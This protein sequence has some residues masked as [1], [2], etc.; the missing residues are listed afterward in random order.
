M[1]SFQKFFFILLIAFLASCKTNKISVVR[2]NFDNEIAVQQNLSFK[3]NSDI[4]PDELLNTWD[5]TQYLQF[6]PQIKGRY[7]WV[8]A[9]ELIFSPEQ[10]F[11]PG[12][13]Y[14]A[15][16]L[17]I[18]GKIGNQNKSV[19]SSSFE[20]HTPFLQIQS[21]KAYWGLS[22]LNQNDIIIGID[23]GFN[24]PIM[25]QDLDKK[26]HIQV[27][28]YQL[29]YRIISSGE[30]ETIILELNPPAATGDQNIPVNIS[31][32]KDL[33]FAGNTVKTDDKMTSNTVIP[34]RTKLMIT[35][36][37]AEM[38]E[39]NGI[40]NI[41]SSQPLLNENL[42]KN[43][44]ISPK[45]TFTTE[46]QNNV[47]R[48]SGDFE[49]DKNYKI[50]I[51]KNIKGIFGIGLES[52]YTQ[53][54]SLS[55]SEPYI[56][57]SNSTDTYLS[58]KGAQNVA[59]NF[60][61]VENI[62]LSVFKIYENNIIHYLRSG[63]SY[64]YYWDNSEFDEIWYDFYEWQGDE[65]FGRQVLEK[66]VEVNQLPK[67]HNSR[68]LNLDLKEI[69]NNDAGKGIYVIS[70]QDSKRRWLRD[71]ILVSISDMGLMAKV[72]KN[73]VLVSSHSIVDA[74]PIEGVKID[75]IS[76]NNQKIHQAS[77][78]KD[79]FLLINNTENLFKNFSI[80]MITARHGDDFNYLFFN[81][82]SVE[83][84]RYE[85]GGKY[86]GTSEF[87]LFIYGDRKLYR[88][89]DSVYINTIVRTL[90]WQ[91]PDNIPLKFRIVN[92]SGRLLTSFRKTSNLEGATE[93]AFKLPDAAITG[94]YTI[95]VYSGNDVLYNS[96]RFS[97]EEFMPDRISVKVKLAK[98]DFKPK[99]SFKLEILA[100]NFFGTPASGRKVENEMSL[101][102]SIFSPKKYKDYN[103][104]VSI[105]QSFNIENSVKDTKTNKNGEASETFSIP[106]L[107]GIGML[108][109]TI[110]TTV[111]DE[112]DRPINRHSGFRVA[113][114][115]VF[116]G[117]KHFD[118]YVNT[119]KPLKF[120]LL[121]LNKD[122]K[123]ISANA[124]VIIIRNE[125]HSVIQRSGSSYRYNSNKREIEVFNK[126]I[127]FVN[128]VASFDFTPTVSAE[129]EIKVYGNREH[130]YVGQKFWAYGAG[131]TDF[132]SFEVDKDGEIIIEQNKET[133]FTGEKAELLFKCPF[134]GK[135]MVTIERADVIEYKVLPI[136]D[137][138]A[139]MT[140]DINESHLPNIY[141]SA[142]AI[143]PLS[144]N[145][146]PLTVAH[147]YASL[148]VENKA[149]Q[150][151]PTIKA[152][153]SVMSRSRQ[154]VEVTTQAGAQVTIA[155]VDEGI[156]QMNNYKTP[157][158]FDYFY[159]KRALEVKSY[160]LYARIFPELK[161]FLSST[162]GD[163]AMELGKRVNPFTNKRIKLISL[164]SGILPTTNGK[165]SFTFDIPQFSG[166]LRVMAVSWKGRHFGSAE[167]NITV[168]DP[169][170]IS[171][172]LPRFLSPNDHINV[173][174]TLSN[175]TKATA[176]V[177]IRLTA[178]GPANITGEKEFK[179]SIPA[180]SEHRVV[181][182]AQALPNIGE[183]LFTTTVTQG[184]KNYIEEIY[185]PVRP[186]LGFIK[187]FTSGVVEKEN[188][189]ISIGGNFI[190]NSV[191]NTLVFSKSPITEFS[192][193]L[194]ELINYPYGCLEQ[195]VSTAFPLLYYR[196][197]AKAIGHENKNINWNP[198][199]IV[200]EA[201]Y[202]VQNLQQY[203]GGML[204][205]S[206]SDSPHWWA[207]AYATHFLIE[208]KNEGFDVNMSV[209]KNAVS[210]L[211]EKSKEK[212]TKEYYFTDGSGRSYQQSLITQEAP[213]SIFVCALAGSKNISLLNYYRTQYQNLTEEGKYLL[214]SAYAFS[215][216]KST[217]R[218]LLPAKYT[219]P[220]V[221]R[222]Q[223][224][225]FN[226]PIRNSA[227]V[228]F[229]LHKTDPN[230]AQIPLLSQKLSN[231][232]KRSKWLSTNDRAFALLALGNIAKANMKSTVKAQ[233]KLANN[234]TY[235]F[236]NEEVSITED[237][238]NSKLNINKQGN[239]K[240]YYFYQAEGF[241]KDG[242]VEEKDNFMAVRRTIFDRFGKQITNFNLKSNDL[243]VV[244][245]SVVS[246]DQSRIDNVAINDMLP[247]CFEIENPRINTERDYTWIKDKSN[248]EHMDIR[249]DQI[250]YF[251]TVN[252][253]IKNF[254]YVVRVVSSGS[255]RIG[256]VSADAM[257]DGNYY[258]YHG[259]G[260]IRVER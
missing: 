253:R 93:I 37:T 234:T 15:S 202:K 70:V 80:G 213:Y 99:E 172:A 14:K 181:F 200:Q 250:T 12:T 150:I 229:T 128:G 58:S 141:I 67:Y 171:T 31:I 91:T 219:F 122:E 218:E 111:F 210:Y 42:N 119:R 18:I 146:I 100:E 168:A 230:N 242:K 155:V 231:D 232:L 167:T 62:K 216:N 38:S 27:G 20:F 152:P 105:P 139:Q 92:P 214:A 206:G 39:G 10:G 85:V 7:Q 35:G 68:L 203:S 34:S 144:N 88:P 133:Y 129:Y 177:S 193:D 186:S 184:G 160:D 180:N 107:Q 4:A 194:S 156:L 23:L 51:S 220:M 209:I 25:V 64:S 161:R 3:F 237:I 169:I 83:T 73:S 137:K 101:R 179:A 95:E 154:T 108:S 54:V 207:T 60:G 26:L 205:W 72:G 114:Q 227:L 104:E 74:T 204:Y 77:T 126:S 201:I 121:A 49:E 66:K 94:T 182:K 226:S 5:T 113:T 191:R 195:V 176:D 127:N 217:F 241:S 59:V 98:T 82:S 65:N 235:N 196:D 120:N 87:D 247:A 159:Q 175:T 163:L 125:Y 147:G 9:S 43:I 22:S 130:G 17:P 8:S 187:Y 56:S 69:N 185:V 228:L 197:L 24:Y 30:S 148:G 211:E 162:G 89:G 6:T 248:P 183:A 164:W 190:Q 255:F 259:H 136:V 50:T 115:D 132:S 117:I 244:R 131:D 257:Y 151:K 112:N 223:S 245:I 258:S 2:T 142:T 41:F 61:N 78:G 256:I 243:L 16:L 166:S 106:D 239:G 124:H 75:F 249:D 103:F 90:N 81:H 110:F 84:S 233:I 238:S 212:S 52:D 44:T 97:C 123:A 153:A 173:P 63:K 118:S 246:L 192:K 86:T 260:E 71:A 11:H 251:T 254:Y 178:K 222:E 116:Y 157:D 33:P 252:S 45:V 174:V 13:K 199:Y 135:L 102:R 188:E 215:G 96:Y 40:I 158:P 189:T 138:T 208:A 165:A 29:P 149:Y 47:L 21:A 36:I 1:K 48:I 145:D 198:D 79:G 19:A 55:K 57:F 240:L 143:R 46:H 140:L 109:G 170:V 32:D 53:S 28:D 134:S 236:D 221:N 76:T 225:S 224:G